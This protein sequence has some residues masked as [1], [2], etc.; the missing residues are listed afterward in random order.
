MRTLAALSLAALTAGCKLTN[1]TVLVAMLVESPAAPTAIV[2]SPPAP[3]AVAQV[4]LGEVDAG[5]GS[6]PSQGSMTPISG[7]TVK[8]LKN[9]VE[10]ATLV[11][12]PAGSGYYEK[13]GTGLY[14]AGAT[15]RFTAQ[16]GA[17][18]YWGEVVGAPSAPSPT[19]NGNSLM[20]YGTYGAIPASSTLARTCTGLCDVGIY[21]VWP[22]SNGGSF[23]GSANPSCTNL[24]QDA[25]GILNL[26]FLDD[27]A[28]RTT[29]FTLAK[30]PCF[31]ALT[32]YPGGYVVGLANLKKGT[33]SSNTSMF[34]VAFAGTSG[35]AGVTVAAP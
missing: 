14:Q 3:V 27:T 15:F 17:D 10:V 1:D 23:D 9:N 34:S 20:A 30:S 2:P 28:W 12:T 16:V 8:L 4:F 11:E 21:G 13:T 35:A 33:V 18:Q 26:A 32:G 19:V 24:P 5:I 7:A 25:A 22:V 29:S 6:P 31:P